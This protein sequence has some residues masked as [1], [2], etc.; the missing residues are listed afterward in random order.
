MAQNR[1]KFDLIARKVAGIPK[2]GR[3]R[4]MYLMGIDRIMTPGSDSF[5]S[6]DMDILTRGFTQRPV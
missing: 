1:D 5:Q 4:V 2:A 3:K 6:N